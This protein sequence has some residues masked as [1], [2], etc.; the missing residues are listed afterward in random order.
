MTAK[1]IGIISIKGGVGKTSTVS[2]LAA[3]LAR[4]FGKK[5]LA[6]DANFSAPNLGLHLGAINPEVTLHHVLSNK[7]DIKE[8]VYETE[9]GFHF[10]PG[11]IIHK[12]VNPL[13]LASKLKPLKKY[14]DVILID[15]SPTLNEEILATMMAS[16]E[17]Y[18]VTTPDYVTLS[19]TL[20]AIRL[21]KER[22]TPIKGI[23]LNRVYDKDFELSIED[24][25][26]ASD[27]NV[28]AVLPHDVDVLRAL[29][30]STPLTLYNESKAANEYNRL[31]G[32]LVKEHFTE[33]KW[34]EKI[35]AYLRSIF[36]KTPK[37]EINRTLLIEELY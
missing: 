29:S 5:V 22:K 31:A 15:S 12:E 13:K 10:I 9:Y 14:Y 17:L 20:R 11:A 27:S 25:E 3:S 16:D 1:T 26:N 19:T 32:A 6:V 37:Q 23:I 2:A 35:K 30:E 34:T 8:S 21:A 24:I 18:V 28:V 4:N 36:G 7:A 33:K